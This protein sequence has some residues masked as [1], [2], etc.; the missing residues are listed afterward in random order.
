MKSAEPPKAT[1]KPTKTSNCKK[2]TITNTRRPNMK[3]DKK[4]ESH[5]ANFNCERLAKYNA[6][7]YFS[8]KY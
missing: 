6:S 7:C 5:I 2:K 1:A 3:A 8:N 4:I